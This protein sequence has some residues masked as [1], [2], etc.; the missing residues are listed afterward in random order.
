MAEETGNLGG[1]SFVLRNFHSLMK[2]WSCPDEQHS[3]IQGRAATNWAKESLRTHSEKEQAKIKPK[4]PKEHVRA[5]GPDPK[6]RDAAA[7][8]PFQTDKRETNE[9]FLTFFFQKS[10]GD[11]D[12]QLP[13]GF[14]PR[15]VSP[16]AL[17][18]PPMGNC[19]PTELS[20][21]LWSTANTSAEDAQRTDHGQ[22]LTG[23]MYSGHSHNVP[24][25]Q[26]PTFQF[27]TNFTSK[28]LNYNE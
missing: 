21:C 26:N 13:H 9:S 6:K 12:I 1:A 8:K 27:K 3:L 23:Y 18:D 24:V 15:Q 25:V 10:K 28:S 20:N 14:F 2:N 7:G 19:S 16:G 17:K 5:H 4:N 11:K 22:N